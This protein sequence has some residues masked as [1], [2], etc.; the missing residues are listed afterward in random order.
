VI[1]QQL[2]VAVG[3][4]LLGI[5]VHLADEAV[6]IDDESAGAGPGAGLPRALKGAAEQRVE[7]ADMPEGERTQERP[8]RRRRRHPAAQQPSGAPGPEH[9]A[10][11]DAVG[12]EHHRV[13]QRHH[14]APRVGSTC[15]VAAQPHKLPSE[16]LDTQPLRERR[17][18]HHAGVR[19]RPLIIEHDLHAV[20]SD[21]LAILHH[22]GDLL[23]AGRGCPTQ[24]QT[25]CSGGHSSSQTG[26]NPPIPSVDPG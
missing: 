3:G 23:T 7:V 17:D 14:L 4:A 20:R 2:G 22:E 10:V 21:R 24:P 12:A 13:D 9:V 15:P 6:D 5:A 18:Q 16:R 11:V 26:R 19:D 8:E 25:A 1:A